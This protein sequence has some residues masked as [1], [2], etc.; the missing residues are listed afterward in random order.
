MTLPRLAA[1]YCAKVEVQINHLKKE[2][3]D[4]K[5][6]T[7]GIDLSKNLF[8]VHGLSESVKAVIRKQMR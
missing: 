4:I 6:T 7:V 8:Q 5:N 2:A 3:Y 1:S